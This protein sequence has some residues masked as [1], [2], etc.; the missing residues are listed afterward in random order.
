MAQLLASKEEQ[1]QAVLAEKESVLLSL[2]EKL[3]TVEAQA[4]LLNTEIEQLKQAQA[5]AKAKT[6]FDRIKACVAEDK[7]EGICKATMSLDDAAFDLVVGA[8]ESREQALAASF[9]EVGG[10]GDVS[11]ISKQKSADE[12]ALEKFLSESK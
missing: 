6:R 12:I 11:A 4:S 10:Q 8:Y 3:Q 2:N 9:K 1:F 7:V 5:D